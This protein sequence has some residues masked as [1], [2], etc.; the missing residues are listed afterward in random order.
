MRVAGR[1]FMAM[2]AASLPALAHAAPAAITFTEGHH[3][4]TIA[5]TAHPEWRHAAER[6][7]YKG[8]EAIPPARLLSCGAAEIREPDWTKQASI[9]WDE[10]AIRNTIDREIGTVLNRPAGSVVIDRT[11]SGTIVF[12]GRGLTGRRIDLPLA[13][14]LTKTALEQNVSIVTLPMIETQ[15]EITVNDAD[16]RE[17]GIREVVTIGESVFAKSPVNRRHNIATGVSKFNGHL[18]PKDAIFSFNET[19]G[20]V[21]EKT[22]YRKELVIQGET[23]IPDYGGGLCQ[24]SSTA[25]RGPWEYGMPI[26]QRKNHSYAVSYYSPQG[27]DATIYPPNV[28]MK[29]RNDTPGSLLIQSFTDDHD[30][31]FFIYYGTRDARVPEVFGP[32]VTDR[33]KAPKAEKLIYTTDIPVGEKRKAGE[34]HDGMNAMWYRSIKNGTGTTL[35]SFFSSYEAR[36]ATFQ[37]GVTQADMARHTAEDLS[38]EP[39]WLPS[40]P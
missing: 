15:P 28:D 38:D 14:L 17:Q 12:E 22:G 1:L 35:E 31:A 30:R 26:V 25:Y 6:W 37:I 29:F 39:S 7:F 2:I 20:P 23:T 33:V 34:L 18:I 10:E 11:A 40:K 24:V 19:L 8:V 21:N 9:D 32:Y 3:I 36:P 27:T 5:V 16:L 4:F 13:A